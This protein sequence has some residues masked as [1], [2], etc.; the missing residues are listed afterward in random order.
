MNSEGAIRFKAQ[1]IT[2]IH[3]DKEYKAGYSRTGNASYIYIFSIVAIFILVIACINYLNLATA[4]SSKRAKE[5]GVRK[6]A[7]ADRGMLF[8][9]FIL[10]SMVTTG[11]AI[12]LAMISCWCA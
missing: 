1:P 10:E 7:G 8:R 2:E 11:F 5:I 3:L 9:Q 6:T 4:T 12:L